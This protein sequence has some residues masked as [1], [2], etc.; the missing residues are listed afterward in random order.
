MRTA[1]ITVAHGRHDHLRRQ[2]EAIARLSRPGDQHIV[3][4]MDDPE[5]AGL[6][7]AEDHRVV[8]IGPARPDCR[9]LPPATPAATPRGPA[10]PS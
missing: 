5:I 4:A 6:V 3:V 9:W 10:A 8:S 2:R 1:L 7:D